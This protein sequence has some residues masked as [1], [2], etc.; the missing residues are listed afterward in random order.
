M[1]PSLA[2]CE[3][4]RL[5]HERSHCTTLQA[6]IARPIQNDVWLHVDKL[7]L[8]LGEHDIITGMSRRAHPCDRF[9]ICRSPRRN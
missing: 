9:H 6:Y 3:H 4:L 2:Q 5:L 1:T 7:Q 8:R